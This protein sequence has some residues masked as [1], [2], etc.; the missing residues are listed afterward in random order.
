MTGIGEYAVVWPTKADPRY[1]P[2][3]WLTKEQKTN[4]VFDMGKSRR[5]VVRNMSPTE[6]RIP[7]KQDGKACDHYAR[8][9]TGAL[10]HA[11]GHS[12]DKSW[13]YLSDLMATGC[14]KSYK[15]LLDGH[16][17]THMHVLW[18]SLGAARA[19]EKDFREYL[20]YIKWWMIMAQTHDGSYVVMP[21][22]DYASTDHVYGTR[23][24]PTACAALI[25]SVKE[26]RLRITGAANGASS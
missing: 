24:F 8:S 7:Y 2:T 13:N 1:K 9:G 10:A 12:E 19:S 3:D 23:A 15:G 20:D 18:G 16:A 4:R 17:S 22:R 11:I 14:A 26:K 6:P 25:L 21:G 5:M